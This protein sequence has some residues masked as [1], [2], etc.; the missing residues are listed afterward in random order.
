MIFDLSFGK[1]GYEFLQTFVCR[2]GFA[3]V[4]CYLFI[5][6]RILSQVVKFN[7]FDGFAVGNQSVTCTGDFKNSSALF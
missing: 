5:N 6:S 1:F 2:C 7:D 3:C 4:I